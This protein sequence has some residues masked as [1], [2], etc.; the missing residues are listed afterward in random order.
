M[1]FDY[2]ILWLPKSIRGGSSWL[3]AQTIWL[4]GNR[5]QSSESNRRVIKKSK[6]CLEVRNGNKLLRSWWI[7]IKKGLLQGDTYSPVGFCCTKMPVMM[8]LE[9][10]DGYKMR[11]P[12]KREMRL[13]NSVFIDNL[14]TY[15]HM[16]V[17][18]I[19]KKD[20]E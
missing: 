18:W 13:T 11:P 17:D 15:Q 3:D 2:C 8:L 16:A 4:N 14:K 7:D 9:E 20:L 19:L 5:K 1:Q 12:G 6:T 10:S